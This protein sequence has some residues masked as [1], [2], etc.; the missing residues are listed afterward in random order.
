MNAILLET[1]VRLHYV[2]NLPIAHIDEAAVLPKTLNNYQGTCGIIS[3]SNQKY[4]ISYITVL[5]VTE[6]GRQ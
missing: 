2:Y 6:E 5:V 1:A 3:I 4:D